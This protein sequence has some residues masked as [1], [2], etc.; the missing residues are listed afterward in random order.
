M[1]KSV[2]ALDADLQALLPIVRVAER[3]VYEPPV[4]GME[5]WPH[6]FPHDHLSVNDW[7]IVWRVVREIRSASQDVFVQ[8][9]YERSIADFVVEYLAE[10]EGPVRG[11]SLLAELKARAE[12]Q[13]VWLV[14]VP[15][16]NVQAWHLHIPLGERC[17]LSRTNGEP[18]A[19][20]QRLVSERDPFAVER[21]LGDSIRPRGQWLRAGVISPVPI[22]TRATAS[23]SIVAS[24]TEE[25][26]FTV[27]RSEARLM[28]ALWCL[29]KPPKRT[30]NSRPLWPTVGGWAPQ[31]TLELGTQ[32]KLFNPK[33]DR[34]GASQKGASITQ[35]GPYVLTRS[36]RNLRSPAE[37]MRLARTG[38]QCALSLL[39]AA[40]ALYNAQRFPSDLERSEKVAEVW[41]AREALCDPGPR[42]QGS[43]KQRWHALEKRLKIRS[44]LR[45][46]GYD[47]SEI[48]AALDLNYAVRVLSAHRS[49]DVLVNL[50][51]PPTL[52]SRSNDQKVRS[53]HDLAL[54]AVASDGPIV[55]AAVRRAT[56]ALAR[57]A[58]SSGW[59]EVKF[60]S[61]FKT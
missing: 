51:Y 46:L 25:L 22:D 30:E 44:Y 58:I 12:E 61:Y 6:T 17:V 27:A 45:G 40:R 5:S 38:N 43:A 42:G 23:L 20:T 57:V 56:R 35:Y 4:P 26:A 19:E 24:G 55:L 47:Q 21:H 8:F 54:A 31:P 9:L 50:N 36:D 60:H 3:K 41:R 37:A 53:G 49:D 7:S 10:A 59:D 18:P 34:Q 33:N 28:L 29:L 48:D 14:N 16:V 13:D 15:L 2:S 11:G 1:T 39:S 52:S 32:R